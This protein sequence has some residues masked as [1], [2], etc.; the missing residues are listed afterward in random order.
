MQFMLEKVIA[1]ILR[2][3]AAAG[4]DCASVKTG[5]VC[6]LLTA[7]TVSVSRPVSHH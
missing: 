5:S 1:K 6:S 2:L 3:R 7:G 4:L